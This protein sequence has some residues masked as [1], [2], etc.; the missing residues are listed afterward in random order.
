MAEWRL[1]QYRPED[2]AALGALWKRCFGDSEEFIRGFFAALPELGGGVVA[3]DEG[4]IMG[5]AYALCCQRLVEADGT[6]KPLGLV[7]GVAVDRAFRGRGIGEAV[8]RA[9]MELCRALGA[10]TVST[11]P[12]EESLAG[13]YEKILGLEKCLYRQKRC[14]EAKAGAVCARLTAGEYS[15]R[16]EALLRGRPH[17]A[18]GAAGMCFQEF[19]LKSYGGALM[20]VGEGL[21]AVSAEEGRAFI[22]ELLC[23]AGLEEDYAASVAAALGAKEAALLVPAGSGASYILASPPLPADCVWN[24]SFD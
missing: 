20:A 12:A 24:L 9:A 14:F 11:E 2:R 5:A 21:A 6:E 1:R 13:W 22:R 17:V 8:S 10:R 23:P 3:E 16:R 7:Y 18:P 19:L 4:Q 15:A